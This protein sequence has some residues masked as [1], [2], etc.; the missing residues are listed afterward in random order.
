MS[1]AGKR[2]AFEAFAMYLLTGS[3]CIVL[4]SSMSY[5]TA[6]FSCGVAQI[7]MLSAAFG[8]GRVLTV[9]LMGHLTERFGVKRVLTGGILLVL[10]FLVGIP[11]TH[12]YPVAMAASILGGVGMGTQDTTC[13]VILANA[14]PAT[15][16]SAMSAGQACFGA[17]CFLPPLFMSAVIV[18]GLPFYTTYYLFAVLAV[19]MLLLL[20]GARMPESCAIPQEHAD[21]AVLHVRSR[22]LAYL[23]FSIVCVCYCAVVNTVNLYTSSYAESRGIA[24]E[25]A[26]LALTVYNLG[27]MA[28]SLTF[29]GVLRRVKP[30]TVLWVNSLV[31]LACV[32]LVVLVPSPAALF[33]GM[34]FGGMFIGVIFSLLVTL[35]T[36]MNP[37]HAGLAGALV[38]VLCGGSETIAP[39]V[40]GRLATAL[41]VGSTFWFALGMLALTLLGAL[42]FR[43]V[44]VTGSEIL[45][46]KEHG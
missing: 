16:A 31:A 4:G 1:K 18:L 29:I 24:P 5:L 6:H 46:E 11:L 43:A 2:A 38:A 15:Y 17:G 45:S 22:A 26:V 28:G 7:A 39:L 33:F 9:F 40:T 36:G 23:F 41:G 3:A 10:C 21:G 27:S 32:S 42:A 44:C 20:P 13:P 34:L 8:L 19:V 25:L 12:S 35:A 14:F 37:S 30:V